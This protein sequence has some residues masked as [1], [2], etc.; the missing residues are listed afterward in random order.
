MFGYV[1]A[2]CVLTAILFGLAPALHVS[3]TSNHDVLKE[4]GRGSV[5]NRRARWFS[6]SIVVAELALSLVLLAGAGLM[7]RSFMKLY[8]LDVGFPTESSDDDAHAAA[9]VEIR[10]TRKP[11]SRSSSGSSPGSRRSPASRRWP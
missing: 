3:K 9:G 1:A 2:I 7:I 8:T 5:G 11:A 6:G 4:G 10:G